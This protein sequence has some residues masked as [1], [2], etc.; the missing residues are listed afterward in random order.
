MLEEV[1][2]AL[3][4]LA[5][6]HPRA[7][8]VARLRYLLGLDIDVVAGLLDIAPRTVRAD[9]TFAKAWLRRAIEG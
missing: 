9:W 2:T 3:D 1:M 8:E 6:R 4:A 7:A 5:T